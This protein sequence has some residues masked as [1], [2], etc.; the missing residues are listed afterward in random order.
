[1]GF[2]VAGGKEQ[3]EMSGFRLDISSHENERNFNHSEASQAMGKIHGLYK[4]DGISWLMMGGGALLSIM[5]GT[6]IVL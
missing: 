5:A 6:L 1:M 4:R 3:K 2:F